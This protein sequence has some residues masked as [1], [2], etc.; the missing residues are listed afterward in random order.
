MT[1]GGR[2]LGQTLRAAREGKRWDIARAERDTRI[3]ARYL[4][5]LEAGDY[6]DLPSAV[7][8]RGFIRNYAQYLGLDPEWCLDLYD[9]EANPI[10]KARPIITDPT[11][12]T[13]EPRGTTLVT[14]SRLVRGGLLLL[15]LAFV[16]VSRLPVPDL[17]RHAGAD[18][19]RSRLGPR[20]L[21]RHLLRPARRDGAGRPDHRRWPP[22]EPDRH[23]VGQRR[24]LDPGRAPARLE[25]HHPG[26]HRPAHRPPIEPGQ[27]HD[28]GQPGFGHTVA[29]RCPEPEL[30]GSRCRSSPA[31]VTVAGTVAPGAAV[32]V[33]AALIG[34]PTPSFEVL[35]LAGQPV[36]VP[37]WSPTAP[38]PISV[39]ADLAGAFSVPLSLGIGTWELRVSASAAAAARPGAQR[40]RPGRDRP[41]R[42]GGVRRRP[43]GDAGGP[44]RGHLPG[45]GRGRGSS[46]RC[47]GPGPGRRH[48]RSH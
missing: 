32:T 4:T 12:K 28:H 44:R 40:R 26:R 23:R 34:A 43:F 46:G 6:R 29:G 48:R 39:S 38:E 25:R 21:C 27:P 37:P 18:P 41:P 3:R 24:V 1:H 13:V 47:V 35:N 5:A 10:D 36:A 19:D 20:G 8:T 42:D 7:Y 16:V 15:V 2:S 22:R 33:R 9:L 31:A 14:T 17:R 11:A 30:A 45:A